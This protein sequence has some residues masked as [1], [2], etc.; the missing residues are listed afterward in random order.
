MSNY[1]APF[2]WFGGKSRV[3][4]I[5]WRAFGDVRNY[6]EPFFGSGAVLL[7]RP[8]G[9]QGIETVNDLDGYVC[10]AWRAIQ[11]DPDAVAEW[12]DWP[13]NENDLH[14]R[15]VWL[16]ARREELSRR[17][18]GNPDYYDAKIAGWW[19]WG[20][21]CWIGTGF[22]GDYGKGPWVVEDGQLVRS[23]AAG[24]GVKRQVVHLGAGQGVNRQ[25][26][27]L[28]EGH[29]ELCPDCGTGRCGLLCW[30][31]ALSDRLRAVRV[32]SGD[33]SRVCGPTPTVKLGTTGVFLDPPYSAE[34][35]SDGVY[36]TDSFTVAHDVR[37]WCEANG[38]NPLLRIALCGYAGEGHDH[39]AD[40]GWQVYGWKA[41]GGYTGQNHDR[42]N[43]NHT[44][45]RIWFSPACLPVEQ[46][47][48]MGLVAGI[49]DDEVE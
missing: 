5:V 40:R 12:A 16:K 31:R 45:E 48:A 8:G 42:D 7:G 21:A 38:N 6:V 10:N 26:V 18:E 43:Q 44:R 33:W 2:P 14:A 36:N 22:C 4:P 17:L 41:T 27:H 47:T 13:V 15:H 30:M 9:A 32:C 23:E 20:M 28:G 25:L 19:L 39:L 3:A 1:T 37:A 29:D 49:E 35:R 34:D 46:Q 24:Q 11:A